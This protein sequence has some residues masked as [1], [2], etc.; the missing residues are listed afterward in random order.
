MYVLRTQTPETTETEKGERHGAGSLWPYKSRSY[1]CQ[2]CLIRLSTRRNYYT[3]AAMYIC[4]IFY[5]KSEYFMQRRVKKKE[6]SVFFL[7]LF[8]CLCDRLL[9]AKLTLNRLISWL[10]SWPIT[11]E[12]YAIT[13]NSIT[14]KQNSNANDAQSADSR[15]LVKKHLNVLLYELTSMNAVANKPIAPWFWLTSK[16]KNGT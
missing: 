14:K 8:F 13:D 4:A 9:P 10:K 7:S 11:L 1:A 15:A 5:W 3:I 6:R 16:K 2:V 12:K